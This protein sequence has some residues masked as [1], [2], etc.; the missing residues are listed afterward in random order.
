MDD[1]D[2]DSSTTPATVALESDDGG[3]EARLL[4]AGLQRSGA[5]GTLID[6]V[7]VVGFVL[8]VGVTVLA[9]H[10]TFGVADDLRDAVGLGR[11]ADGVDWYQ[12]ATLGLILVVPLT[13]VWVVSRA[14]RHR[15]R[16]RLATHLGPGVKALATARPKDRVAWMQDLLASPGWAAHAESWRSEGLL[17]AG[18]DLSQPADQAAATVLVADVLRQRLGE[19]ALATG[20]AVAVARSRL[21]DAAVVVSGSAELQLEALASLGLRPEARTW[22]RVARTASTA[23]VAASYLD[24]EDRLELDLA[25]R[26]AVLGLDTGA[27]ALD[28][29]AAAL[30]EEFGEAMAEA[31]DGVGGTLGS[32]VT[33][34]ASSGAG[35][36]GSVVRQM[37]TFTEAIGAQV[38]EGLVVSAMLF[39]HGMSVV[40][41]ALTDDPD[42][43]RQ[44][45]PTPGRVPKE[46]FDVG[47]ALARRQRRGLRALLRRRLSM[48]TRS[49]G[50]RSASRVRN[51]FRRD[52]DDEG[53][54]PA[55]ENA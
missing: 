45:V 41:D 34:L 5:V 22:L 7:A 40:G 37:A 55:P 11:P 47:I 16:A 1:T 44:I 39:H 29:A 9:V 19:R 3:P 30:D 35:I 51:V 12:L 28:S 21:G 53:P 31:L 8:S 23:V 15:Y 4:P 2:G 38:T 18:T 33:S 49:A 43:R 42:L 17:P 46:L 14:V 54:A 48:A 27:D 50:R 25:V 13:A 52:R 32:L 10:A 24:I 26:A 36:T 20:L 6:L